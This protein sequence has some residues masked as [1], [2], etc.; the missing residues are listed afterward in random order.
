M[1]CLFW[2][3]LISFVR[4]MMLS[5]QIIHRTLQLGICTQ[6]VEIPRKMQ[7]YSPFE[8]FRLEI[9]DCKWLIFQNICQEGNLC[10]ISVISQSIQNIFLSQIAYF[11]ALCSIS[12]RKKTFLT[13]FFKIFIPNRTFERLFFK[14][15]IEKLLCIVIANIFLT[16]K[17]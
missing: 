13:A 15:S 4:Y 16:S 3:V 12:I 9:D 5:L 10:L 11:N 8:M 1:S 7:T 17:M 2:E 14:H 6:L